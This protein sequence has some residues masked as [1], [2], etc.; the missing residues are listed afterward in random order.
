[1][2]PNARQSPPSEEYICIVTPPPGSES[3]A[4]LANSIDTQW[5]QIS[6]ETV[7]VATANSSWLYQPHTLKDLDRYGQSMT[8]TDGS[9]HSTQNL[10]DAA[11]AAAYY[12][13][14]Q[15]ILPEL[16]LE[17]WIWQLAGHYHLTCLTPKLMREASQAFIKGDRPILGSWAK[18]KAQREREYNRTTLQDI[19]YLGYNAQA[20][21]SEFYPPQ[22]AS[23]LEYLQQDSA[24]DPFRCLGYSYTIE[25]IAT[26]IE[27]EYIQLA[28]GILPPSLTCLT[29]PTSR[30]WLYGSV[31]V[32]AGDV[33]ETVEVVTRLSAQERI[34]VAK[35]CYTTALICFH[36]SPQSLAADWQTEPIL[37][38]LKR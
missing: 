35:A 26:R 14:S 7:I 28:T 20:V 32:D 27:Q 2:N 4:R 33:Q 36:H 12:Q 34:R 21:V 8:D 31:G 29:E 9:V 16:T 30:P 10:L 13:Y 5:V 6:P 11:I 23:L 38:S 3:L 17:R 22:A 19:E 25:R 1:M 15:G 37:H 18:L 24:T